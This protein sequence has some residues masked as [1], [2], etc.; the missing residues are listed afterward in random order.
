MHVLGQIAY[1]KGCLQ[2]VVAHINTWEN[3]E[4]VLKALEEI[5]DVHDHYRNFA[6]FSTE[7]A[8]AYIDQYADL[9]KQ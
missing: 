9:R 3:T 5:V 4:L 2:T 8:I 6:V 1:K 7:Q